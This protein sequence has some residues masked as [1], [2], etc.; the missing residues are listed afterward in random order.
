MKQPS[1]RRLPPFE[2]RKKKE[3]FLSEFSAGFPVASPWKGRRAKR[4]EWRACGG[5]WIWRD[6]AGVSAVRRRL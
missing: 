4:G 2:K 1:Q 6:A 3:R 5:V